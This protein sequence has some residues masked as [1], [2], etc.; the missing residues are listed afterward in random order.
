MVEYKYNVKANFIMSK[1]SKIENGQLVINDGK[2]IQPTSVIKDKYITRVVSDNGTG[3]KTFV[4]FKDEK[5]NVL[6]SGYTDDNGLFITKKDYDVNK[7][8][9]FVINK[10]KEIKIDKNNIEYKDLPDEM[11]LILTDT[12]G[13]E[14]ETVVKKENN[15]ET[16]FTKTVRADEEFLLRSVKPVLNNDKIKPNKYYYDVNNTNNGGNANA[17]LVYKQDESITEVI[18]NFVPNTGIKSFK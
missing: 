18:Y 7:K 15:Y 8:Y 10:D 5:G 6:E 12:N 1:G 11:K 9:Y 2:E 16:V 17:I 3:I 14:Y 13:N 4:E